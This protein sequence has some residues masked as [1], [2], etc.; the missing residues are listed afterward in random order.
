MWFFAIALLTPLVTSIYANEALPEQVDSIASTQVLEYDVGTAYIKFSVPCAGCFGG[1][2]TGN[3]ADADDSLVLELRVNPTADIWTSEVV[4]NGQEVDIPWRDTL[5]Q[6]S[7]LISVT[8][9]TS[10]S[11]QFNL[12]WIGIIGPPGTVFE[13]AEVTQYIRFRITPVHCA[14]SLSSSAE[15]IAIMR[16]ASTRRLPGLMLDS[17]A[18]S[19]LKFDDYEDAYSSSGSSTEYDFLYP[20]KPSKIPEANLDVELESLGL[21]EAQAR[22]LQAQI[23]AKKKAIAYGLKAERDK[24]CLKHLIQECDGIICAA[25]AIAQRMCDK[26]GIKTDPSFGY[27]KMKR[28]QVE[29]MAALNVQTPNHKQEWHKCADGT[30]QCAQPTDLPW[31]RTKN[32]P[33]YAFHANDFVHTSNPLVR[34]LQGT[35]A[36][37]GISALFAFLRHKCMSMRKRV[38]RAADLEEARNARAYRRAARRAEARK[39]WDTFIRSLNCFHPRSQ[40]RIGDYE[41][42]RALILQDAFL[43]QDLD[44]AE[45]GEVME[46]EIRELRYAHEI[47]SSLVRVEENR[48]DLATPMHDP[49][50]PQV[51]LPNTLDFRSRAN[52]TYTLPSY[53]TESLPDYSSRP[54]GS[55]SSS[56]SGEEVTPATSNQD[57][58]STPMSPLS[59]GSRC[60]RYTP[61]SS[62]LEMTPR[63]SE[64]TLRTRPSRD[65]R[66]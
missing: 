65:L 28:P 55:A 64:E 5:A 25:K 27:A 26:V 9:S 39:R 51:P 52:S 56:T 36:L 3:T 32:T 4:L 18:S 34:A 21:L 41:E 48:Y 38:E 54:S 19:L 30:M 33:A 10:H 2:A 31:T 12:S 44:Q 20:E 66:R 7:Q 24:M 40:P 60:T 29:H 35:L 42:K 6:S 53:R 13:E 37:L 43:E 15:F 61:T 45:K 62:V 50:P 57:G 47:V 58:R 11:R 59:E 49:P 46:A 22:E 1:T 23:A 14:D 63:A 8:D 17:R 16:P